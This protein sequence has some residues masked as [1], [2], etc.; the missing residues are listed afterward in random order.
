MCLGLACCRSCT[1]A[2]GWSRGLLT[3]RALLTISRGLLTPPE[4][5]DG[6]CAA[7]ATLPR[8]RGPLTAVA[9][10]ARACAAEPGPVDGRCAARAS[11]RPTAHLGRPRGGQF[12]VTFR[13]GMLWNFKCRACVGTHESLKTLR[14]KAVL[15]PRVRPEV[16]APNYPAM[17]KN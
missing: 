6:G 8:G 7:R 16:L 1:L 3:S 12:L 13:R 11:P 10:R 5:V 4:P 17:G 14:P 2:L 15:S 9:L